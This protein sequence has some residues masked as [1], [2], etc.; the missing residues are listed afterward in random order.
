MTTEIGYKFL[1]PWLAD[2]IR[3]LELTVNRPL[4]GVT[5]G[6]HQ[7][8]RHGA[9]VEFA[10]Y[11]DY[12]PGDPTSLID[13]AVYAR[14]DKY[15]IR[16]FH[17]EVNIR[18]YLMLD[19][20]AS[21]GFRD[22]GVMDKLTYCCY[23]AA[24]LMYIMVNQR[25]TVGLMA[26]DDGIREFFEPACSFPG[27]KPMLRA[28]EDLKPAGRSDIDTAL[29][30]ACERLTNKSLVIIISD[31]LQDPAKFSAGMRHL[32]H[33][34]HELLLIQVMDGGE[35]RLSFSELIELQDLEGNRRIMINPDEIREV[36]RDAV[37]HFLDQV[38]LNTAETSARY[39]MIDTNTSIDEALHRLAERK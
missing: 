15:V 18:A 26:F 22:R 21:Q 3:N 12:T 33:D 1:P 16:R 11:R 14:S 32:H 7:S 20:S 10:E 13:W 17:E 2:R 37:E 36:Y 9:S 28:L 5:Q 38:Q 31:F 29:H 6:L 34:G 23:L 30:E 35:L 24:G 19:T 4:E 25:D 39:L 27:I 8:H